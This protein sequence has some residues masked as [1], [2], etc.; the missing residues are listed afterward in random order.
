MYGFSW[1]D[2]NM[3]VNNRTD[4]ILPGIQVGC[5]RYGVWG[6][7]MGKDGDDGENKKQHGEEEMGRGYDNRDI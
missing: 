6:M 4:R 7:Y 2:P 1:Y 5:V 3:L